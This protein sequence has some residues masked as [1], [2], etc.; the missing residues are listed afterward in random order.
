MVQFR[1]LPIMTVFALVGFLVLMMFGRWQY[2]RYEMKLALAGAP[3]SEMTLAN[4]EPLQ[5][6]LQLVYGVQNG[7]QGWRVFAPVRDGDSIVFIDCDFIESIQPPDWREVRY[8]AAL[9]FGAPV[10]GATLRPE[11]APALTPAPR[12][13][14][15]LWFHIDLAAMGRAAGLTDVAD[16]YIA[17]PYVGADGRA[18]ANPF[19]HAPGADPLPPE[20]HLGYALTWWGLALVLLAVYVAYHVSVGRLRLTPAKIDE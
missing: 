14:Q 9:R 8:P 2:D 6:G 1:P 5:E 7:V 18:T 17:T 4:Y 20:R 11:P 13:L 10:Q 19:A 15:R 16:Y 3:V 12:P